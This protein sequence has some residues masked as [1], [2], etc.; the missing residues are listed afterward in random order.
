MTR[1]LINEKSEAHREAQGECVKNAEKLGCNVVGAHLMH[2]KYVQVEQG[3][4]HAQE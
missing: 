3:I 4:V 1:H 2:G